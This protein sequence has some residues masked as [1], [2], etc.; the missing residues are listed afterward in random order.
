MNISF[1]QLFLGNIIPIL[2]DFILFLYLFCSN[3]SKYNSFCLS[4]NLQVIYMTNIYMYYYYMI[5]HFGDRYF[6]KHLSVSIVE[7]SGAEGILKIFGLNNPENI[8]EFFRAIYW[9]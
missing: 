3:K 1:S 6:A 8:Y 7:L 2:L 4:R 5:N 9:D